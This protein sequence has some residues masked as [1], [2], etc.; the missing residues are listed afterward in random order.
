MPLCADFVSVGSL[1]SADF[2]E[3]IFPGA[4][5]ITPYTPK[6]TL[7]GIPMIPEEQDD[8]YKFKGPIPAF[9]NTY[10]CIQDVVRYEANA[11]ALGETGM[12]TGNISGP[13]MSGFYYVTALPKTNL[14]LL[15]IENWK[16]NNSEKTYNFNCKITQSLVT[17]GAFRIINGTC[18]A[19]ESGDKSRRITCPRMRNES[20]VNITCEFNF[21]N[22]IFCSNIN[23]LGMMLVSLTI[24]AALIWP[25]YV[26]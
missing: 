3:R 18:S 6:V 19:Q 20:L 22:K 25:R 8:Y 12:F 16:R 11:T 7:S 21:A 24:C 10:S 5:S 1:C 2:A 13:C 17:S 15:V 26:P 4:C 14:F 23:V 9:S